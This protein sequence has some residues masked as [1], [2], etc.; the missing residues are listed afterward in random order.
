MSLNDKANLAAS[1]IIKSINEMKEV[2]T[3]HKEKS[4]SIALV[5]TMGYLHK[6][7]LSLVKRARANNDIVVV[8]IFVNPTQFGENEDY[9]LYPRDLERD[10]KLSEDA[11]ADYIFNP[12]VEEIYP[13]DYNT[14]VEVEKLTEK[15]CGKSRLG[16][17]RG[18]TTIVNKLFN[19][20]EPDKAYFGLKDAQQVLVIAKMVHDLNMSTEIIACPIVREEDGLAM[21]SRN[22]N[23]TIKERQIALML[24]KSLFEAQSKVKSGER[25]LDKIVFGI[26]ANIDKE[27]KITIDYVEAVN[28][29]N[30]ESTSILEDKVLVALAVK[31]GNVRLI[32]NIILEGN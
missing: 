16:H 6:G 28:V 8:S 29:V 9:G 4:M 10:R 20:V 3:K 5:P 17:F 24:S 13:K 11:G 26:K 2:V 7:H 18:V 21:S 19:I 14:Y 23:L 31:I 32:D 22:V 1:K 15:L 30:L 25:N 12:S 27:P